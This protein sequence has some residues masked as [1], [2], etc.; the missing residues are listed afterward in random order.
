METENN[1]NI[2][3][4]DLSIIRSDSNFKFGVFRKPTGTDIMIHSMSCHP[5]ER[6]FAGITYV[7]NRITIYLLTKHNFDIENITLTTS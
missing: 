4:L 3:F 6:I 1:N 7:I 5:T 2:N